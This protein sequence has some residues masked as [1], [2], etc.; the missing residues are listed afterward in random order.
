MKFTVEVDIAETDTQRG[1]HDRNATIAFKYTGDS[2]FVAEKE[3]KIVDAIVGPVESWMWR[4][5][6]NPE[7]HVW[8]ANYGYDS[9]D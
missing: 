9:G 1:Y 5:V 8:K 6:S 3:A 4:K 7:P 2:T